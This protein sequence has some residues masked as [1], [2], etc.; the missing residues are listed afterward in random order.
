MKGRAHFI[1]AVVGLYVIA[2]VY[3]QRESII[4]EP[5]YWSLY[6]VATGAVVSWLVF[7]E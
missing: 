7:L 5:A 3:M 6:G 4:Q 2:G 1:L